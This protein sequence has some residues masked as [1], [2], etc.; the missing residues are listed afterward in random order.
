MSAPRSA[1]PV[2]ATSAISRLPIRFYL[3]AGLLAV[4]WSAS[5]SGETPLATHSFFPLWLGYILVVDAITERR[6]GSSLWSR[7][8]RH[9]LKLFPVSI[10]VWWLFEAL[11]ARLD[12]WSYR[13]P[14][15]YGWLAYHVEA[16]LAFSTVVS[17]LFATA[18]LYHTFG[19]AH[20]RGWWIRIDPGERGWLAFALAG[21][22]MLGLTLAWP[23]IFFPLVWIGIFFL[24]DP[25]VRRLGGRSIAAQ[26][27]TGWWG[28]VWLLF[29]SAL[30][31]GILWE[32]WNWRA[33]P[34][35]EYDI[36]YAEW[37]RLFEMPLLGYGGYLPFGLETYALVM[38][39]NRLLRIWPPGYLGFDRVPEKAA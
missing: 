36:S 11:N 15:T 6:S 17:A 12:N 26:V 19:F 9:F 38:L 28:T 24:L 31:C 3:G 29:A 30:T 8:R 16:S 10:P 14:H 35:W 34:K 39:M 20:R 22:A 13:L 1:S 33:M 23:R 18:N 2:R 37:L 21:A 25:M 5:W 32:M 7:G 27:E 4:A